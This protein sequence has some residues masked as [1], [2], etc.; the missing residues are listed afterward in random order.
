MTNDIH[1]NIAVTLSQYMYIWIV[2][3]CVPQN[4]DFHHKD[5]INLMESIWNS[6]LSFSFEI[7]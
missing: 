3:M 5:F 2:Y 6:K 4:H 7:I 1:V